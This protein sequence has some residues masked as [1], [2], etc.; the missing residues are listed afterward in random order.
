MKGKLDIRFDAPNVGKIRTRV[1]NPSK[2]LTSQLREFLA[3]SA[4][5]VLNESQNKIKAKMIEKVMGLNLP[6]KKKA[7]ELQ[8]TSLLEDFFSTVFANSAQELS[9][10][11]SSE[12][13]DV[14]EDVE[15]DDPSTDDA[16]D[17]E[18]PKFDDFDL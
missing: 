7:Y 6:F 5:E 14:E 8:V 13:D 1:D 18:D 2:E 9:S 16:S 3:V 12:I 17:E 4:K 15:E 10:M 11:S